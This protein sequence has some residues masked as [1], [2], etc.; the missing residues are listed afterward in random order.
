MF[1]VW[2]T[3]VI[4]RTVKD[5]ILFDSIFSDCHYSRPDL[6]LKG[7]RLGYPLNYWKGLDTRVRARDNHI[8]Q[9]CVEWRYL[10]QVKHGRFGG[11]AF[12]FAVMTL[13]CHIQDLCFRVSVC[14]C[15]VAQSRVEA[16][17]R[18]ECMHQLGHDWLLWSV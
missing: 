9:K 1:C 8:Y 10:C 2:G 18:V 5:V 14:W 17:Y 16:M 4:A 12:V 6:V 11:R 7:T 13:T 15:Y 3:G